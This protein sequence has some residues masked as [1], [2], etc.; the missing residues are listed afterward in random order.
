M[1]TGHDPA[2]KRAALYK[3]FCKVPVPSGRCEKIDLETW[4]NFG[5]E[6]KTAPG[7]LISDCRGFGRH[8]GSDEISAKSIFSNLPDHE[9]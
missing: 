3:N 5:L 9:T 1:W 6:K 7:C 4:S 8:L 2:R